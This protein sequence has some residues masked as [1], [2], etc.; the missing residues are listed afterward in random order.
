VKLKKTEHSYYDS[1]AKSSNVGTSK[2]IPADVPNE[3]V[4]QLQEYSLRLFKAVDGQGLARVDFFLENITNRIVFNEINTFPTMTE[5][6]V[7]PALVKT[8]NYAPSDLIDK[9]ITMAL[10]RKK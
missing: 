4:A 6:S 10:A 5:F 8:M 7:Y 9:L 3:L 1:A 2:I